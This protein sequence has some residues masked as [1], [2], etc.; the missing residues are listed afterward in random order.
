MPDTLEDLLAPHPDDAPAIGAPDRPWLDHGGLRALTARTRAALRDAGIGPRDRVAIVLPNGPEM[1]AAFVAD[2]PERHDRAAEP[3]LPRRRVRLLP[4]RTSGPGRSCSPKAT[5]ARRSRRPAR[6]GLTVLRL[7]VASGRPAGDFTLRAESRRRRRADDAAVGAGRHRADPAH[8]G[9][10]LAAQDRAA[11]AA[12]PRRL[13]PAHRRGAGADPGGPLPQRDAALP[14]PRPGRGGLREPRRR[15]LDLVRAG[16]RRAAASSAGSMRPR[17]PGTPPCPTMH[18]AIL[19]RAPR[20]AEAHRPG[21][22]ALHPLVLRLAAA[23]GHAGAGRDLRRAGD[24]EL[25]HDRGR[26]PDGVEP[27]AAARAEARLGRDRRR[28]ARC[29]SPTRSRTG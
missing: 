4:R 19:A 13:G 8:L 25:R 27:A 29:A 10:H 16:L 12:Q 28:P 22:A 20:N 14:H 1:A 17:P 3:G 18:Q 2:R 26:A 11:A 6:H 7:A 23:A 9:H 5:T 24:R 15:R 21:A